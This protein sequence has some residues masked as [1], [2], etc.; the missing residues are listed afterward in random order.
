M[1]ILDQS[2]L[3]CERSLKELEFKA[4]NLII[5]YRLQTYENGQQGLE[6]LPVGDT[7][8]H[9]EINLAD[10][11]SL[12]HY[13]VLSV[14]EDSGIVIFNRLNVNPTTATTTTQQIRAAFCI[15]EEEDEEDLSPDVR[16]G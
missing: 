14:E 15:F 5:E 16:M 4:D 1:S 11:G 13:E 2:V 3:S 6:F 9:T 8:G 7:D 12:D 10:L